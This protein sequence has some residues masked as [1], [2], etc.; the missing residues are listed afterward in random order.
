M[1]RRFV[2][3]LKFVLHLIDVVVLFLALN[4]AY[5]L[6]FYSGIF[7][8][9]LGHPPIEVYRK[10]FLGVAALWVFFFWVA[11]LYRD[12]IAF[13]VHHVFLVARVI[14]VATGFAL[15]MVFFYR[16]FSYSRLTL[17]LAVLLTFL[18]IVIWHGIKFRIF[19]WLRRAG[20]DRLSALVVGTGRVGLELFHHLQSDPELQYRV[21]GVFGGA[22]AELDPASHLG[23]L[24]GMR[25]YLQVHRVSEVFVALP[26]SQ[27]DEIMDLVRLCE[28][29]GITVTVVPDVYSI[30]MSVPRLH[31]IAGGIPAIR[32]DRLPIHTALGKASKRAFDILGALVGLLLFAPVCLYIV[33]RQRREDPGPL[34]YSQERVGLD[35]R[36]FRCYKFR[37]MRVDAESDTGPVWATVGDPRCTPF[38]SFMRKYSLDEIPQFWHVLEG[39]M[40]LVGPRPERPYF[41]RQ[42]SRGVPYYMHRHRVKA[43]LTGWAQVNGLRGQSP[44]DVRTR[45]DIWY[46]ENWSIALDLEILVKTLSVVFLNP[47]GN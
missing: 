13:G 43:G 8:S 33:W 16:D 34:F 23:A 32:L 42:F 15:A 47:T 1:S 19:L 30:M 29:Q 10:T 2:G 22:T 21:L 45:Y 24:N 9:E 3:L 44:I 7:P 41:V 18:A 26:A 28:R 46:I 39:K 25:D 40:S 6:R 36:V 11:G 17:V 5:F 37:S 35:G 27:K 38:G 12:R 4:G 20:H 14:L 31:E